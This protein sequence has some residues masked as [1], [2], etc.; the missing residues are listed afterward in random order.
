MENGGA[1]IALFVMLD[2]VLGEEGVER[3][4]GAIDV[5]DE[6]PPDAVD[7]GGLLAAVEEQRERGTD[8]WGT[9]QG[10]MDGAP[11]VF[12][13]NLGVKRIDQLLFD[14]YTRVHLE[15][16]A[17]G[18]EGLPDGD[19]LELIGEATD[20]LEERLGREAL[21]LGA[22]SHQGLR[23]IHLRTANQGRALSIIEAWAA[24]EGRWPITVEQNLDPTWEQHPPF[25]A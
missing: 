20:V 6:Q 18:H 15:Y 7:F 19:T 25:L 16:G 13:A 4:L 14:V 5:A 1:K 8:L 9:G 23:T 12:M 11:V 2:Q 24:D 3:W 17:V 22:S 10:V 21:T